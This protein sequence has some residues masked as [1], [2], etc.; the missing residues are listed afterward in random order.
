MA[1]QASVFSTDDKSTTEANPKQTAVSGGDPTTGPLALLVG[2]GR[3]YR[4]VEDLAKAYMSADEFLERI[5]GENATL[6]DELKRSK[7][8]DDVLERLKAEPSG[9]PADKGEQKQQPTAGVSA[10]EV[11]RIVREQ[12]TGA[13]TER[14]RQT[15][16]VKADAAMRKLFGDKAR[17]VF[18]KAADVPEKRK[19]LMELASVAPETFV[20][21]F[22]PH[23]SQGSQV[24]SGSSVNTAALTGGM[25]SGRDADPSCKEFYD[26]MRRKEP[27]KYYSHDMQ[28]KMNRAAE[29]NPDKFFGR[30]S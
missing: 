9:T 23:G 1:D 6:R 29:A 17:E 28:I 14:T 13:E 4:N 12:L 26:T 22:V 2:E 30:S 7:T 19:A 8:I 11:A 20:Q 15:N 3:K 27:S 10:Q 24:D 25:A 16:L 18:D 5:K 21:L